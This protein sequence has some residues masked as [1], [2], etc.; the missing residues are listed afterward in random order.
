M[1][2][3]YV[4]KDTTGHTIRGVV[5]SSNASGAAE[6]LKQ[7]QLIPLKITEIGAGFSLKAISNMLGRVSSGEMT[8]FTRQ[9]ATMITAGL[10]LTDALNLLKAQSSPALSAVVATVLADVQAGMSLSSAMAKHPKEFSKVY[11]ALVKAGEAA[12]VMETI[13]N[14]LADTSEKSR[15]FRAKVGGAMVYPI[16]ILIGMAVVMALMV[17][18][19]IPKLT[20]LYNDFGAEL[21]LPTR[22]I[23]GISNFAVNYWWLVLI[24]IA[25]LS[26]GI[27]A[28]L[29]SEEGRYKFD[30]VIYKI[31]IWGPLSRETMLTELTRTL[32]LLIG[33]GVGIVEAI[34]IVSDAMGNKLVDMDMKRIAKQVE[35]G[36]PISISFTESELFPPVV[37]QM[38]AVGEETGKL[39]EVLAKLSH[40]FETEAEQKVKGLTTAIEPIILIILAVGVGFLMYAVI[41]PIYTITNKF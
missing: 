36:F 19:V 25:G 35:K 40:Y 27:R 10:P 23:I 5:E 38:V 6:L 1:K 41:M 3:K 30:Q 32:S 11:I 14:R 22:I 24:G 29:E 26:M 13:L 18:V 7:Q 33:A 31:P 34:N 28:Y 20:S 17:I 37:G 21:P 4:V 39:D 12:G 2:Y 16:I 9:L 15:E 8:N